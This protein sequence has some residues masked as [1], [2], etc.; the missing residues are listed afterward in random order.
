MTEILNN[1]NKLVRPVRHPTDNLKVEMRVFL[2][3]IMNLDG[4]NQIVELNAWLEF[5]WIDY[6][7]AWNATKFENVTSVRFAGGENQIWRPDILLYN[8]FVV[9]VTS[10][11]YLFTRAMHPSAPPCLGD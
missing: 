10:G 1:Y 7:L 3:Q 4:K 11:F 5:I 2:Q 8:R 6:R 9:N